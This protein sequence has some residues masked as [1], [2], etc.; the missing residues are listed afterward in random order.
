MVVNRFIIDWFVFLARPVFLAFVINCNAGRRRSQS[1]ADS[2][3]SCVNS[4]RA[5]QLIVS[6][7]C[8]EKRQG[9]KEKSRKMKCDEGVRAPSPSMEASACSWLV[10]EWWRCMINDRLLLRHATLPLT[11]HEGPCLLFINHSRILSVGRA[12]ESHTLRVG[13]SDKQNISNYAARIQLV[14]NS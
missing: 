12:K 5:R 7:V 3:R 8:K 6:C 13:S 10:C 1:R 2:M 14:V 4:P 11:E 9:G